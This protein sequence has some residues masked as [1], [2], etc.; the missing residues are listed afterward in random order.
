MRING[1][2]YTVVGVLPKGQMDDVWSQLILPL[3]F[4]PE[5]LNHDFHWLQIWGRLKP[6][7]TVQQAQADMDNVT[8]NIAR[9]N[10]KSSK[11]WGALIETFE[12]AYIDNDVRVILWLLFGA[13]GFLL[14]IACVN[15]ANLLLAHGI[16]RHKE[17]AVRT[18]LGASKKTIFVQMLTESLVLSLAGGALGV[19]FGYIFL[20]AFLAAIP[21]YSLP[22]E[23]QPHLNLP[24]LL[25][26]LAATML[27]G[28]L[29]GYAP[30]WFASRI[31]PNE[32]LKEG[33]AAGSGSGRHR[34]RRILVVAE[35]ALALTMLTGAGLAIHSFVN[36]IRVDLGVRIDHILTFYLPVPDIRP[37][38]PV[39]VNAYYHQVLDSVQAVPGVT[40]VTALTGLPLRGAGFGMPFTIAGQPAFNDPSQR[41]GAGFGMATPGFFQTFGVQMVRGRSFTEQDNE[42][43]IKV[44]VVNE[45]FAKKFFKDADPLQQRISVEQL[46]PGA[47]K[48]GP[49]IEWQVV[50]VYH[51][52][53]GGGPQAGEFPEMRVPF[54]QSP[55]ST[56]NIALRTSGDPA[57][58]AKSVA[59]AVHSV[60]PEVA[61]AHIQTMDE[62]CATKASQARSPSSPSSEP[63]PP[64]PFCSP[65][66]ASTASCPSPS[67]SARGRS[68]SAWPSAP[69]AIAS[70]PSSSAKASSSPSSAP[71]SDS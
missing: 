6:G 29:S 63:S 38:D 31:N 9:A 68:H 39:R 36:L 61:L 45:T 7:V 59:A 52:I 49:P 57:A 5:Q 23:A 22:T 71:P 24:V 34:L 2:P 64:S 27:A 35:F 20:R 28:L 69:T 60:D 13:C 19:A 56:A 26:T 25:V 33:G 3:V 4:K 43:A 44:M 41:P 47:T 40:S 12:H 51:T 37:R 62:I 58:M 50:G 46:I 14:L 18:A 66:S 21:Q 1:E 55:W 54:W 10:P 8:A 11:G 53:R 48:L 67:P 15:V 17:I 65:S 42:S 16:T 30:A 70:S 32:A